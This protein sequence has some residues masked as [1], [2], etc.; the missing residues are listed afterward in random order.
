MEHVRGFA[1]GVGRGMIGMAGAPVDILNIPASLVGAGA[2]E[3]VM[4]S[5]W[6]TRQA[7]KLEAIPGFGELLPKPPETLLGRVTGRAG[8]E[9]GASAL[10]AAGIMR[11]ARGIPPALSAGRGLVNRLLLDPMRRAP[12]TAAVGELAATMGAGV[13]AGVAGEAA[14]GS[15]TAETYGQLLGGFAPSVLAGAPTSLAIRL[16]RKI[17]SRFS[18]QAQRKMASEAVQDALGEFMS[19]R[20]QTGLTEAERL[21]G[22]A[23]G[24]EPS[25]AEATGHPTL[26][27]TQ[28]SLEKNANAAFVERIVQRREANQS[29]LETFIDEVAPKGDINPEIVIDAAR[30]RLEIIGNRMTRLSGKHLQQRGDLVNGIATVDRLTAGKAL[31]AGVNQARAEASAKMSIRADELGLLDQDISEQFLTWRSEL[32]GKY[33]PLSRFEDTAATPGIYRQI[34]SDKEGVATF[35]DVKA[36]RERVSDDLIDSLASANPNR[37]KV[38]F[39]TRL[40]KDVDEFIETIAGSQADPNIAER[41]SQFR[42]EYFEEYV[43]P[44]ESGAIFKARNKDGTGFYK[45]RDEVVSDM[46]FDNQSAAKQFNSIFK[47]NPEM[48]ELM[49][50]SVLDRL[51]MEVAPDGVIDSNKMAAFIRRHDGSL[52]ELP[53]IK[54]KIQNIDQAERL[55]Q[56]RQD[57]L[58]V[59]RNNIENTVLAKQ[60]TRYGAQ[61]ATADQ[62]IT[63]ALQD[64]RKMVR[65][66]SFISKDRDAIS[67][68]KRNVWEKAAQG[69][70]KDTMKFIKANEQSLNVLFTRQHVTDLQD[71]S[72][73]RAMIE[74]IPTQ[75]AAAFIPNPLAKLE[76]YLGIPVPQMGTRLYA[77]KTGRL[78]KSYLIPEILRTVLYKKGKQHAESLFSQALYDPKV[79]M[80][81]AAGYRVPEFGVDRAKRIGA[82]LFALGLPYLKEKKETK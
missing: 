24:L 27:S 70:A 22:R 12:G 13:G 62:I 50:N 29:A 26:I 67:A 5:K 19:P 44:F 14:P 45:A 32:S 57:R 28:K 74:M 20:S 53:G 55:L 10:P 47:N 46:F 52:K 42:K 81:L 3:P 8:E 48:M 71:V 37:R 31:R 79:A 63:G 39:L 4:G 75:E 66:T 23:P 38:R 80:E 54:G 43:T 9:I 33:K 41:Y 1:G 61:G 58:A 82:R 6:L 30:N 40:K 25:L 59:R 72:A 73:I 34:M 68:L 16:G 35:V 7:K 76:A 15:K 17:W 60:L 65:L 2:E 49:E 36:I 21:K 69:T 77:L 56:L 51:R 11:A 18:P 78:S 64:Y